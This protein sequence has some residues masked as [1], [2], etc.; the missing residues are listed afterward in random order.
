MAME[1]QKLNQ[2]GDMI[3]IDPTNHLIIFV[4]ANQDPSTSITFDL[5]N[6]K[7]LNATVV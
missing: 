6:R 3:Q 4:G 7:I 1:S 2:A 5:I